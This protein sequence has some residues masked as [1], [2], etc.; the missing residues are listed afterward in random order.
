[1][2]EEVGSEEQVGEVST[3]MS[4]TKIAD[5]LQDAAC[6]DVTQGRRCPPL[7]NFKGCTSYLHLKCMTILTRKKKREVTN[8]KGLNLKF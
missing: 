4:Q 2:M 3:Q 8:Q 6:T 5:Q 7:H 1:M